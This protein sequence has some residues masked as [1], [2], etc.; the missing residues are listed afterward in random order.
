[1]ETLRCPNCGSP[2]LE[3][4]AGAEYKCPY[5]G[6]RVVL[7]A[8]PAAPAEDLVDVVLVAFPAKRQI[9]VIKALREAT[10]LALAPAKRATDTLPSVVARGVPPAEAARIRSLLEAAGATVQLRPA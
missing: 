5:C 9:P 8:L 2:A 3:R 1:M 10:D 4:A 6:T 7:S